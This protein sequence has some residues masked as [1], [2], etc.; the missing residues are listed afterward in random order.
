MSILVVSCSLNPESNS[1]I[2]ARTA[3]EVL[4]AQRNA[5]SWLD[6]KDTRL[7]MCD[8]DATYGDPAVAKATQQISEASAVIMGVPIYNYDVSA[9][10]KN[11][12]ELTGKAWENKTVAF[13]CAAGGQGSYM[14]VMA[15]AN[16][17]MLDFRCLIVPRFVYATG[18]AFDRDKLADNEVRK[19]IEDLVTTTLNLAG[20]S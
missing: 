10:A 19:R 18:D 9:T 17:L 5:A 11:L 2:L 13:L 4:K 1:R 8:G 7:P 15:F 14:S 20:R 3:H 6:L 12:V 16:S